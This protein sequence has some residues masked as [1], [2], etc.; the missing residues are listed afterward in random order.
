MR[1]LFA[2]TAAASRALAP[3]LFHVNPLKYDTHT[4]LT[5]GH[6][7]SHL[8]HTGGAPLSVIARKLP[9][10]E[11]LLAQSQGMTTDEI[12]EDGVYARDETALLEG[13]V[14]ALAVEPTHIKSLMRL[15]FIML[16][17]GECFAAKRFLDRAKELDPD[18]RGLAHSY[19]RLGDNLMALKIP[20]VAIHAY[21]TSLGIIDDI[22]VREKLAV[23]YMDHKLYDAAG[24]QLEQYLGEFPQNANAWCN[25]GICYA[26]LGKFDRAID[27]YQTALELDPSL[28]EARFNLCLLYIRQNKMADLISEYLRIY[29]R[30]KELAESL[31]PYFVD[32]QKVK[33]GKS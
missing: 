4:G 1:I 11:T 6:V 17:N 8:L 30:D 14:G 3:N 10:I 31:A 19:A 18:T 28:D 24:K 7:A 33:G 21:K 5:P 12:L 13:C 26:R 22:E 27:A 29:A 20:D 25:L 16:D 9:P 15:A 32:K 2:G 23:A